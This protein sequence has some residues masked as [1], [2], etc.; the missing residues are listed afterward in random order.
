[1]QPYPGSFQ[2]L[3]RSPPLQVLPRVG[4]PQDLSQRGELMFTVKATCV[5][6]LLRARPEP[7]RPSQPVHFTDQET[8]ED[9]RSRSRPHGS[10]GRSQDL[11]PAQSHPEGLPNRVRALGEFC[12]GRGYRF[13][14]PFPTPP[15]ISP[16]ALQWLNQIPQSHSESSFTALPSRGWSFSAPRWAS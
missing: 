3:P 8:R 12:N 10:E 13:S 15:F 7:L 1:M 14:C 16:P 2:R 6:L 11:N 9:S 5:D 4:F